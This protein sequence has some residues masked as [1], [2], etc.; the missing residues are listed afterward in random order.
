[1]RA[2][3]CSI[4]KKQIKDFDQFLVIGYGSPQP[5][6]T[7]CSQCGMPVIDL[8]ERHGLQRLSRVI[9]S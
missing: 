1:M 4:C 2:D 5:L 6:Y 8:L 9:E 7:L 3:I